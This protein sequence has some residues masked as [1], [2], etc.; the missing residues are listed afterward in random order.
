MEPSQASR[1]LFEL[2]DHEVEWHAKEI[3]NRVFSEY[4]DVPF[5]AEQRKVLQPLIRAQ[6]DVLM[7]SVLEIFDNVGGVIPDTPDG[8]IGYT[9]RS[10]HYDEQSGEGHEG[11]R[12]GDDI[13]DYS[14][15]WSSYLQDKRDGLR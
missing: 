13:M 10:M 8:L 3:R 5:T 2:I 4:R 14:A 9:I 15:M 6:L 1:V 7:Q 11:P 12:I